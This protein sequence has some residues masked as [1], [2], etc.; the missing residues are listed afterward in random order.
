MIENTSMTVN[1]DDI[2]IGGDQFYSSF[3]I[4]CPLTY[5]AQVY[6][7]DYWKD[8]SSSSSS[9]WI[10]FDTETRAWTVTKRTTNS[11]AR[12]Y[13]LRVTAFMQSSGERK[14]KE[15]AFVVKPDCSLELP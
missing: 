4:T 11:F 6:E 2:T 7:S 9:E 8:I 15:F 10:S 14:F 12:I 5:S 13:N 3:P 1:A